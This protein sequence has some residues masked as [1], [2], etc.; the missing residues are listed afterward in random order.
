MFQT[1]FRLWVLCPLIVE[2]T[3]PTVLA[4][5]CPSFVLLQEGFGVGRMKPGVDLYSKR[6]LIEPESKV[7]PEWLRFLKGVVDSEDI[8]LNISREGMQ[9][10]ALMRRIRNVLTRRVLRFFETELKNDRTKYEKFF[11]EFGTHLKEGACADP[12]YQT[13]IAK[14]LLFESS[15][16]KPGELTTLDEYISRSKP[17]QN[18]IYYLVAPHRG[19]AESSPYMEAFKPKDS[20]ES[21]TEVLYLYN[22]IDDFVMNNLNSYNGRRMLTVESSEA[23][24]EESKDT[25]EKKEEDKSKEEKDAD[26]KE[27]QEG[28]SDALGVPSKLSKAMI[29]ELSDWLTSEALPKRLKAVKSTNRL[30]SSPAVITDH[31]SSSLRRM[32]R[33][34]DQQRR[35]NESPR[36]E[37]N[38]LPKQTLEVNPSHPIICRMYALMHTQP[39]VARST[40]E[41]L[42]D[43]AVIAAGLMDDPRAMLPRLNSLMEQMLGVTIERDTLKGTH[44]RVVMETDLEGRS[45]RHVDDKEIEFETTREAIDE[46]MA[47]EAVRSK[48]DESMKNYSNTESH[49]H[50]KKE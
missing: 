4:Y 19:L 40:A 16:L 27:S 26:K 37:D 29:S 25:D 33:M 21:E 10:S 39:D 49:F 6:V 17:G 44:D 48:I 43:N 45:K 18:H 28:K 30:S 14:L 2:S 5:P 13:D 7:M 36:A 50:H 1:V 24:P 3:P 35:D 22:P 34:M 11:S 15:A 31:E 41:Q 47:D 32:M 20:D 38:M 23:K 12:T 9:D 42:F 8:P 46:A